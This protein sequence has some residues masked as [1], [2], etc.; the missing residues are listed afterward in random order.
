MGAYKS[1]D[2]RFRSSIERGSKVFRRAILDS[3]LHPRARRSRNDGE[4]PSVQANGMRKYSSLDN[5]HRRG[6]T[7]SRTSEERSEGS[8][9]AS[10]WDGDIGILEEEGPG[11][12]PAK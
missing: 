10:L 2:P 9:K 3:D 6:L 4:T 11:L 8:I 7:D 12:P 1:K 5:L